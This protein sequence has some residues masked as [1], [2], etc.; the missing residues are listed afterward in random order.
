M[1]HA[2]PGW[3]ADVP[4]PDTEDWERRAV[5]WL[6]DLCPPDYRSY[7]VLRKHPTILARFAREHV[8]ACRAGVRDGVATVRPA[9]KHQP[10]DVVEET[11]A[12]YDA[13][14]MRLDRAAIAVDLVG[15]ALAGE[16][17]RPR[18]S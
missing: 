8:A 14:A 10:P 11:I 2:P 15:R 1:S 3:P 4:P 12:A 9:L 16:R 18:L 13:E 6:L 7:G 5:N 17:F